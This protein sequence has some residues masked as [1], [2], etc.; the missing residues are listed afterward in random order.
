MSF[1]QFT[2]GGSPTTPLPVQ[3]HTEQF[4]HPLR[5]SYWAECSVAESTHVADL[6]V[7]P[8]R[9]SPHCGRPPGVGECASSTLQPEHGVGTECHSLK[10]CQP[11]SSDDT[12]V[13][14][15]Y[16]CTQHAEPSTTVD[17]SS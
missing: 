2:R 15:R 12:P 4:K 1:L 6:K 8:Q 11:N 14:S 17:H 7:R 3:L 10:Q 5:P 16:T 13:Y 9:E